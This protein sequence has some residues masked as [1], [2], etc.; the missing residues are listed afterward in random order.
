[1]L[2]SAVAALQMAVLSEKNRAVCVVRRASDPTGSN[3]KIDSQ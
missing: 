1:M 3:C 2:I